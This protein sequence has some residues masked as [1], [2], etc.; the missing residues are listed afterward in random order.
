MAG[1]IP[2]IPPQ[3]AVNYYE[4]VLKATPGQ[5]GSARFRAAFMVPGMAHCGGG[6]GTSTFDMVAAVDQWVRDEGGA[7]GDSGIEDRGW[8][9]RPHAPVVRV[10]GGRDL[11]RNRK[12]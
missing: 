12:H 1:A 8:Q 6:D 7:V 3:N 11:Q 10:S 5:Q 9:G 2:G 4:S